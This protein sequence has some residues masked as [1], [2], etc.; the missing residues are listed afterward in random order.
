MD[1]D[2]DGDNNASSHPGTGSLESRSKLRKRATRPSSNPSVSADVVVCY[3]I[4]KYYFL[5][6]T[7]IA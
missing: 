3:L 4:S 2:G 1:G 6:H 5:I 7:E